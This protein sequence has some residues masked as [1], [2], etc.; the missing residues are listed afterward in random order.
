M[1]FMILW[2]LVTLSVISIGQINHNADFTFIPD[3]NF[4]WVTNKSCLPDGLCTD[5]VL[6]LEIRPVIVAPD[7]STVK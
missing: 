3:K 6:G 5:L 7:K 1:R 4:N 2:F